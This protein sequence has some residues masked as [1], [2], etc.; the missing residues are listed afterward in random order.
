MLPVIALVGRPNVGKSTLFNRLTKSRDALVAN[1]PGLTRDRQYGQAKL[2]GQPFIVVDTGGIAGDEEG[3]DDLMAKQSLQAVDEADIVVFMVD[4]RTGMTAADEYVAEQLRR[5]QKPVILAVNKVDGVHAEAAIA[6]YYSFGYSTILGLA[7]EHGRGVSALIDTILDNLE[8]TPV[9]EEEQTIE[10]LQARGVKLAVVGR[11]NV[12]K[13]TLINRFLGEERVVVFDMPGTTRDSIYIEMER[14][15]K[16]YT[17]IDTAGVRRRG[18]V[19]E[20]VE[21]FSV[22]KTLQAIGDSNVVV[23]VMDAREP[24][25]DQDLSLISHVIDA[26]R[27]MVIAINKWDGMTEEQREEVK[28]EIDRRLGF[29]DFARIH[30]ISALHGSNVGHLWESVDEAWESALIEMSASQLTRLLEQAYE[31]HQPPAIKG[32][33]IKLRYAHPGG[34]NPPIIVIHGKQVSK[35]QESYKRYLINFFRKKLNLIGTPIRL[36]TKEGDNPFADKTNKSRELSRRQRLK[37]KRAIKK[38][39]KK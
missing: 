34:H 19:K 3:I 35:L 4:A 24:I 15:G 9:N 6:E 8:L 16:P 31:R 7:A 38:F 12:G 2:N 32:R 13:S 26:G 30:F 21:K 25:T 10:E 5:Q 11:P 33:R 22:L 28:V 27:S 39:G 18:K 20:A 36:E 23:M 1:L 14:R 17:L 29:V 37:K